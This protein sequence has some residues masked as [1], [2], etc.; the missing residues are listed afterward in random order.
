MKLL[1]VIIREILI[2]LEFEDIQKSKLHLVNKQFYHNIIEDNELLRRMLLQKIGLVMDY[3]KEEQYHRE[4]IL[5]NKNEQAEEPIIE[6]LTAVKFYEDPRTSLIPVLLELQKEQERLLLVFQRTSGGHYKGYD[7]VENV[8]LDNEGMENQ[9]YSAPQVFFPNGL[10]CVTGAVYGTESKE[11]EYWLDAMNII[12]SNI[13]VKLTNFVDATLL[14]NDTSSEINGLDIKAST[15]IIIKNAFE[16]YLNKQNIYNKGSYIPHN[17]ADES[18]ND[19]AKSFS[20]NQ[21]YQYDTSCYDELIIKHLFLIEE[22]TCM[23]AVMCL[24]PIKAFALFVHDTPMNPEDHPLTLLIKKVY[25]LSEWTTN[26]P[27]MK[28]DQTIEEYEEEKKQNKEPKQASVFQDFFNLF[29]NLT[30]AGLIPKIIDSESRWMEFDQKFYS[31]KF[32][33]KQ[34]NEEEKLEFSEASLSEEETNKIE[35]MYQELDEMDY[36]RLRLVAIGYDLH[37]RESAYTYALK[38]LISGRFITVLALDVAA[39]RPSTPH[40]DIGGILFKGKMVPS[41]LK[42]LA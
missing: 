19:V 8:F 31:S 14:K 41:I 1:N 15:T 21:I 11:L 6:E 36:Y 23:K 33:A 37:T 28:Q 24:S 13:D 4:I 26:A 10:C 30:D 22:I 25:D 29:Q 40:V 12:D 34:N 9:Y 35:E 27:M 18:A 42:F 38:Q 2:Y 16:N 20:E 5:N 7:K 17:K 32:D 39:D 3:D